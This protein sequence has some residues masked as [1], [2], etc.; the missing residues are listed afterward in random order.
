VKNLRLDVETLAV[1]TFAPAAISPAARATRYKRLRHESVL[2]VVDVHM[3]WHV[4]LS[5][6]QVRRYLSQTT[7]IT[8]SFHPHRRDT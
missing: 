8:L 1:V 7:G 5:G 4:S 2:A 3:F 6:P